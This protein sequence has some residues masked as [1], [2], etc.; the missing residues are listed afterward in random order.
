MH[1][2]LSELLKDKKTENVFRC[3]KDWHF[4]YLGIIAVLIFIV[5][6]IYRRTQITT[7]QKRL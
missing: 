1:N 3:L 6:Y 4:L 5:I 7:I 2:I